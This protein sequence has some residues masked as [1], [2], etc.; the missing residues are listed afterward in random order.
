M[1]RL[2]ERSSAYL[3]LNFIS[4]FSPLSVRN[5]LFSLVGGKI[6][7]RNSSTRREKNE[8]LTFPLNVSVDDANRHLAPYYEIDQKFFDQKLRELILQYN[9]TLNQEGVFHAIKFMYTHRPDPD[10]PY[11]IREQYI[12]VSW[13]SI[14]II[15][16]FHHKL[17]RSLEFYSRI[18]PFIFPLPLT[19]YCGPLDF[20]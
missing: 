17:K 19:V 1:W 5:N 3:L 8:T 14:P 16:L 7:S 9:Y 20:F 2:F 6:K 10:N 13:L 11:Y 4:F 15:I 18:F 12:N